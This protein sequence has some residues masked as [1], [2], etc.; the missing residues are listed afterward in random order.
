M[1][2]ERVPNRNSPPAVLLRQ[3]YREG[4]KVRKRTLANLS[5]LPDETVEG[6]RI[7]LKGGQAIKNLEDAFEIIRSRPHGHVAAVLGSLRKIGLEQI[8]SADPTRERNLVV[9]MIVA[10]IIDPSSKLATCRGLNP[11]T[12]TSTLGE[13]LGVARADSDELYAAM[14]WLLEQQSCIEQSLAKKHLTEGTL[15]L[16]D[17]SSTYFEGETCPLAQFGYSRDGKK[18]KLQIIFGLLCNAQGCPVAV[19][20]FE[21]NIADSTTLATQIEKVRTRFGIKRVV[22]VGDRGIL[23]EAR[24][25]QELKTVEGLDWITALRAPQIRQLVEQEY[26]QLSLFDERDLAEI[27]S[28]DYP[29]ERLIA[30]RN[31]LLAAERA[32]NREALLQATEIELDKIVA[33]VQREKR[34]L[35]GAAN[36]GLRVGKILNRF[37]M[38]KH[39]RLEITDNSFRYERDTR[40]IGAEAALD[41]IYVIRTSVSHELFDSPETVRAYKSLSTVERAFRSYKTVDLKV[42]PIYHRLA[43]RVRAHVFLCMLAYYVE[44]H[45]RSVLATLLFDDDEQVCPQ[46]QGGSPVAPASRSPHA[47]SKTHSKRTED[48]FPV[49]SFGTLLADL[50]TIVKNRVQPKLSKAEVTFDK[51]TCPTPL[52]QKALDLLGVPL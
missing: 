11:E 40:N 25:N 28:P 19:E 2:I 29:G 15:V 24:I 21:G 36:I 20:V 34:P 32:S 51:I 5:K 3:S 17:V 8:I 46:V 26:L 18:G 37:K 30:C 16:Y 38:A 7:L 44:W 45:M 42:R 52:Q 41:G 14:D 31:P 48:N 10:R 47:L 43:V 13:L 12:C 50:A 27:S 1:H 33:A 22:F 35:K 9:A 4:G 39:F 6:L 23:T 49:H